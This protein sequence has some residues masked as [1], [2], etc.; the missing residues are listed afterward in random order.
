MAKKLLC[1]LLTFIILFTLVPPTA[2]FAGEMSA[3]ETEKPIVTL[4]DIIKAASEVIRQNEGN[5][6][7]VSPDDNGA[8]SIGWIQWHANRALNLLKTIVDADTA[9]ALE[10]LGEALYNEII[11]STSWST[12]TLTEDERSKISTLIDTEAGRKAQD[13]LAA[14]DIS[15]YIN[16]AIGLG[17]NDPAALV[18]FADVENQCG[19]GGSK[20]VAA[21]AAALAGSYEAITLEH[22]HEAAMTGGIWRPTTP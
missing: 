4:D 2:V 6:S 12:R 5:Y 21:A 8:L 15:S 19:S 9:K 3:E 13:D 20:R 7:S 1:L 18:Y 17:I 14:K 16:R 10:L 22:M 11:T